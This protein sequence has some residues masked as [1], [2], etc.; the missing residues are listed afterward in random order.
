ML[1]IDCNV[2]HEEVVVNMYI[3]NP[4]IH[5]HNDGFNDKIFWSAHAKGCA[6]CPKCGT[7]IIKEFESEIYPSDIIDLALRKECH[8][9]EIMAPSSYPLS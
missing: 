4:S 9:Y 2:C 7:K 5:F 3:S 6:I 8:V 1:K